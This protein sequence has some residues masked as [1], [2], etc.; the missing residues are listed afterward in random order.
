MQAVFFWLRW[1]WRDLRA[2][3]LSVVVI[4]MIIALGS[5]VY[6][7]LGSSTPWRIKAMNDG[8]ARLNMFDLHVKFSGSSF[9][10]ETTLNAALAD[11]S[12]IAA[13]ESRLLAQTFVGYND[14][15]VRGKLVGSGRA[16]SNAANEGPS[17]NGVHISAGRA[18]APDERAAVLDLH[19][20]DYYDLPTEGQIELSGGQMLDYV[21][22]GLSPEYFFIT[23]DDGGYMAQA[24][25]AV[26]FV[27]LPVAQAISGHTG[28]V[29]DL[30]LTITPDADRN[31]V[32]QAVNEALTAA[33]PQVGFEFIVQEDDP[34]YV[35]MYDTIGMNQEIYDVIAILF[36]AG[37]M[38]GAFNLSSRLVEAQRREIGIG[39]A[40]G[41]PRRLLAVRPLLI[42]AQISILGA[43]F[44][45]IMGVL[46]AGLS[47]VW[48]Q[49]VIPL[50]HYGRLLQ[51][52]IFAQGALLGLVLPFLATL[53]PVWRAIR[54]PP[55]D[56]IRTGH[57]VAKG[58]GL[59]PLIGGIPGHSFTQMPLRNLLRAPRR[60]LLTALGIAAAITT[61][62]G[63]V[64]LL[65]SVVFGVDLVAD[66][67]YKQYPDRQIV[68]LNNAYTVAS[69]PVVEIRE[70]KYLDRSEPALRVM[71]TAINGNTSFPVIIEV[72]NLDN[73]LWTPT[74]VSGSKPA[75]GQPPG[76]LLSELA[77]N[78]LDVEV[79]DTITLEHPRREGLFAYQTVHS[80]V[81]VDGLHPDPWR[82]FTFTDDAHADLFG[83]AG[84]TNVL[85]VTPA[86]GVSEWDAKRAL[87]ASPHVATV[88]P[89]RE[90]INSTETLMGEV[91]RFLSGVEIAVV[92][93]AF[94]IAFNSTSI[95]LNEREREIATMFA[96][97]LRVRT[98]L[99]MAMLENALTGIL[100]TLLGIGLGSVFVR[101]FLL[102]RM[103]VIMPEFRFIP[104]VS[105]TTTLLAFGVGV[106][107]V[108][109][110]PLLTMR[111][112]LK[113]D[114]PS[115][116]RVME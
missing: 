21:G 41:L 90:M 2:R 88:V 31:A 44:G 14:L 3:W 35:L 69:A 107:V 11:V 96:F 25:F 87:F 66:E 78:S 67:L 46:F 92:I 71:G 80:E 53:Y 102:S 111:R 116:L 113:M 22:H 95:N 16:D 109:L 97:G 79:G 42:G 83:L 84:M 45:I 5:G 39:M 98:V 82:T 112:M 18:P 50:P 74:L 10:D 68:Y 30:V 62:V 6:A 60:T 58:G 75:D 13:A 29:N 103:P 110:A 56:A 47:Q 33:F 48:M 26:V 63:M 24:S 8:F 23:T 9:V 73:T 38:F 77:A 101:W 57:L 20:A 115:T 37:A 85:H 15:L 43:L 4:A 91:I 34:I 89:V 59:A 93:L 55:V 27:S 100:G 1:S 19:F 64:G 70:S 65:D 49:G 17:V 40:L 114:V 54:V 61:L 99:R 106:V 12:G 28:Q 72:L 51:F 76:L 52:D 7:G 81:V 104:T 86:E 94:L 105:S 32:Q 108:A 36:L